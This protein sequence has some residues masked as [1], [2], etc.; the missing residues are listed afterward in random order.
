MSRTVKKSLRQFFIVTGLM[1]AALTIFVFAP[2]VMAQGGA[3]VSVGGGALSDSDVPDI[4]KSLSG[5]SG[6]IR[7]LALRIVNFFLL[8]LGL[9][10][11]IMVIYGGILYITAAGKEDQVGTAKKVILYAII[12]IVIIALSF[13]LVNTILKAGTGETA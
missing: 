2:E 6:S 10:A 9:V 13:A 4:V 11:V 1:T 5:G 12:G 3:G 7:E 8:F